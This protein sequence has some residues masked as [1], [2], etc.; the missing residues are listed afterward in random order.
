MA[1]DGAARSQSA[2][3]MIL[4]FDRGPPESIGLAGGTEASLDSSVT[5][6]TGSWCELPKINDRGREQPGVRDRPERSE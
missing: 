2:V 3:G 5:I 1:F 4:E 6:S